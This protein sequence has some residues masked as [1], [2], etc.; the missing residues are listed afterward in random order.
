MTTEVLTIKENGKV[1]L[2]EDITDKYQVK[3]EMRFR[4]IEAQKG[5][6]LVPMTDEPMNEELTAELEQWQEIG[7][8]GWE[9][10]SFEEN[11]E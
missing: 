9:M 3:I 2:P 5:I 6:L 11:P 10:F 7:A 8:D 1:T 4:I